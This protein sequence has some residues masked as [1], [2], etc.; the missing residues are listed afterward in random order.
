MN[1]NY[2]RAYR[3]RKYTLV[4]AYGEKLKLTNSSTIFEIEIEDDQHFRYASKALGPCIREFM[5]CIRPIIVVVGT[6]LHEKYKGMLL[7]AT[8]I[9]GNNNIH[10]IAFAIIDGENDAS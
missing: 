8:Y 3:A 1:I 4:K 9:Y 5:N 7:I 6:H 2:G 10:K